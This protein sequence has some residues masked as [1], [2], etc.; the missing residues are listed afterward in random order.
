[1]RGTHQPEY[2]T[3]PG[4]VSSDGFGNATLTHK[5]TLIPESFAGLDQSEP[6][7]GGLEGEARSE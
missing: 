4:N 5:T 6:P 7:G 3:I 2:L 1:V